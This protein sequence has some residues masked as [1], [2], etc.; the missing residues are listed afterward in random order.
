[1]KGDMADGGVHRVIAVLPMLNGWLEGKLAGR[2]VDGDNRHGNRVD[3]KV[4]RVAGE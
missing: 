2:T 1:M 3:L 4:G